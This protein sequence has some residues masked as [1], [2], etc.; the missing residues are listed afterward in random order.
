MANAMTALEGKVSEVKQDILNQAAHMEKTEVESTLEKTV[1]SLE[2]AIKKF[3]LL[4]AKA[5]D[6]E[7]RG[8][9]KNLR[10]FGIREGAEGKQPLFDFIN[11]M[12]LK[13]LGLTSDKS[14]TLKRVHRTLSSS[15]P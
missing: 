2:S 10:I 4:E 14:F 3:I 12:L 5:D 7:N 8:R 9:R 15:K 11:N 6:L 1:T 13:W